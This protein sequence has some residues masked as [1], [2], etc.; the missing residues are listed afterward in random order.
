MSSGTA[1]G[2]AG[3]ERRGLTDEEIEGTWVGTAPTLNGQIVL[4]EYDPRW[5]RLYAREAERITRLLGG[6]VLRLEHVGSTSVPG[7][8]AKPIIDILLVVADPADEPGY[9]PALAAAGYRL[10]IREPDWHEHRA[11]KGPDTD[12]NLHVHGPGSPEITRML[13]FRDWLRASGAD[14]ALY[15]ATKRELAQR[16]WKYVQNYADAKSAVVDGIIARAQAAARG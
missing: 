6:R 10:V 12:I 7:L 1:A 2:P 11:F 4:R 3:E 13:L 9:V 14:R 15:E 16:T 8:A 5:P